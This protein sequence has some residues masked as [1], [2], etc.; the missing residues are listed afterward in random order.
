MLAIEQAWV[1]T[2]EDSKNM[3]SKL[4]CLGNRICQICLKSVPGK[5][6]N[7]FICI[8]CTSKEGVGG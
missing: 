4:S 2:R 1:D 3:F 6:E 7:N 8:D 5:S